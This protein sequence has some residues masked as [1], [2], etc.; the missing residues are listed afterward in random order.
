MNRT[1]LILI[2]TW[3]SFHLNAQNEWITFYEQSGGT[4]TPRYHETI[5]YCQ[6]LAEASN[7]VHLTSFGTSPQGR[8]LPLL[9][10]DRDGLHDPE[11]IKS[12]GRLILLIQAC[13]HPGE[14]EGKDAGMMLVRDLI[15]RDEGRGTKDEGRGTRDEKL[16][17]IRHLVSDGL[18]DHVSILFIPIFNVDGHERFGP[19]NRINQNGPEE[20]GWRVTSTNL[21]LNR[22]Y[23]KADAP[24]MKAWLKLYNRWLPDFFIDIHT[25]DGA[26]YQYVLTYMMETLGQMDP[27]LTKWCDEVFLP[28][29]TGKLNATGYPVF[30]Y[31]QFRSWH[32]P[33]SG[34]VRDVA[35]PMLS[36]GYVALRNRP[37]LLIETHMLKPYKQR[38]EATYE[39]L[40]NAIEILNQQAKKLQSLLIRA[41]DYVQSPE[42]RNTPFPLQF[43]TSWSDSSFVEFKGV[44]YEEIRSDLTGGVWF[45]YSSTP[46]TFHLPVF[47]RAIPSETVKLPVSY[48]I[49][50]EWSVVIER[51][52]LHGILM[53]RLEKDTVI[54]VTSYKLKNPRWRSGPYEGRHR[55]SRINYDTYEENRFFPAG[56]VVIETSQP[57]ARVIAQLLEPK[58]DGSLLYWGFFDPVFEQ[59]EYA[60]YYVLEPLAKQMLEEDPELKH[61]FEQK[62]AS[63]STFAKSQRR[64]LYWFFERTPY[65]DQKRFI[66]PVARIEQD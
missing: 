39:C 41:D 11:A 49:P 52:N 20:M 3:Y 59:K 47:S 25:S 5:D 27:G 18:L 17:G 4:H 7:L 22:D 1:V 15:M 2:F 35:P 26:D 55:L 33:K 38:V 40:V 6:K 50:V 48:I 37:G 31:V 45:K 24:E 16:S 29:W 36:Q 30:P 9:I 8:K 54:T 28:E 14:S 10:V 61:E 66:Y 23:L 56:S 53:N 51:L 19:Y 13:I 65:Y 21:N 44:E 60:E 58:G 12:T 63:D 64:I 57:A 46:A 34:L 32:D 43:E 62:L 42:F